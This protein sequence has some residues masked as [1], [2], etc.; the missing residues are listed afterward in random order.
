MP[1]PQSP[2]P[3][4]PS[5]ARSSLHDFHDRPSVSA[6]KVSSFSRHIVSESNV[7]WVPDEEDTSVR[8]V[9]WRARR[10]LR[11]ALDI[12]ETLGHPTLH[13]T[14]STITHATGIWGLLEPLKT[15]AD[16]WNEQKKTRSGL[17]SFFA[18]RGE[19][20]LDRLIW[21][22]IIAFLGYVSRHSWLP[23]E[24]VGP[25]TVPAVVAPAVSEKK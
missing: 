10:A 21:L 1:P 12:R 19:R 20:T 14:D 6:I 18:I 3:P 4:P 9:D 17:I 11:I 7:P 25:A 5:A 24:V 13:N 8:A 2:V 15:M 16:D 22:A 23:T